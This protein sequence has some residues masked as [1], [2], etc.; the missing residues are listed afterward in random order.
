MS[1]IISSRKWFTSEKIW[2]LTFHVQNNFVQLCTEFNLTNITFP[3]IMKW[4]LQSIIEGIR[5]IIYFSAFNI[6]I[7]ISINLAKAV[8]KQSRQS[9]W[10]SDL[11]VE[12]GT[13]NHS[14]SSNIFDRSRKRLTTKLL[15]NDSILR[16]LADKKH[17]E[18]RQKLLVSFGLINLWRQLVEK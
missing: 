18:E 2:F 7:S 11:F 1:R 3:L 13:Q 15:K 17:K 4:L 9:L 16:V 8:L 14:E 5:T 6:L 10:Q 12:I